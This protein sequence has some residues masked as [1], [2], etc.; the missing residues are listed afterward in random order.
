MAEINP[1][2][3][4]RPQDSA[5]AMRCR[6][7]RVTMQEGPLPSF[8]P[9]QTNILL[10]IPEKFQTDPD[11]MPAN[12]KKLQTEFYQVSKLSKEQQQTMQQQKYDLDVKIIELSKLEKSYQEL[13]NQC[14]RL[15]KD[16][17]NLKFE[18]S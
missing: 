2:T 17:V 10:K 18:M 8:P 13:N 15:K 14:D 1:F 7:V 6:C 4:C 9:S 12:Y 16:M 5:A 11:P 3:Q